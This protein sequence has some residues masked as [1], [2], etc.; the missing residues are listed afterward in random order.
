[1][2]VVINPYAFGAG[3]PTDPNFSSVVLLCGFVGSN[4][5]TSFVDESPSAHTLTGHGNAQIDTTINKWGGSLL[6]DGTGDY[7]S[8]PDSTDWDLGSQWTIETWIA[9]HATDVNWTVACQWGT[10]AANQAW[11]FGRDTGVLRFYF[12]DSGNTLRTFTGSNFNPTDDVMRHIAIDRDAT[13]KIRTYASGVMQA[14]QTLA[15]TFTTSNAQLQVGSAVPT[16]GGGSTTYDL[17]GRLADL[18]ITKGIARYASDSGF[19]IPTSAYPR[20]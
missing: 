19:T 11:W 17:N 9:P 14:S 7:L 20:S 1:M 6:L 2:S 16:F 3:T 15:Q 12:T 18:R 4:G 13:G 10:T 5:S 8:T